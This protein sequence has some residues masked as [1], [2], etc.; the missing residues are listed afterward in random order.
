[1]RERTFAHSNYL[2]SWLVMEAI[3]KAK[4]LDE[5]GSSWVSDPNPIRKVEA[6]LY[7]MGAELPPVD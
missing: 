6:S 2:A 7:M 4:A 3:R 5:K 1:M